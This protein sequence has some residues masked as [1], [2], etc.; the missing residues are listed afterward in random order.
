[1][2]VLVADKI[3][4][5]GIDFLRAQEDVDVVEAFGSSPEKL[6]ELA[7]D[8]DA[9]IVRSAS[10]VTAEIIA[11]APKLRAVG[12][13]GVGVDNIDVEAATDRG[14]IVMNTPGG[15][16]IATAE[17]AFT[18]LLCSARPVPQANASMKSGKWDKKS[19]SGTELFQKNLG[20]LGLGRIGAE[21]AKRANAFGMTVYA[22]DPYLTAA[23]AEQ[24]SVKKVDLDEL[25]AKADFITIHMP[26]TET[27]ENM[28]NA[29]AFAKMKKGVRIINCARGG[30][31]NEADLAVAL[32]QG[33]V[34]ATGLD[35]F[36]EEP[37]ADESPLRGF[38][39][40]VLTP[41]L[42]ASTAEAQENVGFEVAELI[43][44]ALRG[45][46]IRNSVNAPSIDPAVLKVLRPYLTLA[47]KMGTLVQQLTPDQVTKM[48][49]VYSGK[50]ADLDVK[51]LNRAIQRGYLRKITNDVND[52][53]APRIM[54]R[55]GISGEIVKTDLERDY[56]ELIRIEACDEDDQCHVVEGTLLGR[57]QRPRLTF[58]NG[59]ELECP[60]DEKYLLFVENED[61]PGIVGMI[62]SVLAKHQVNISNMSLSRNSVGGIAFNVCGLDSKP[63]A[64][65]VS[66]IEHYP[67]VKR[68]VLIDLNG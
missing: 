30:L 33:I 23:R 17:L 53:N 61:V 15:N 47:Y 43:V 32:E 14:V 54:D 52:V 19:F 18:H 41:H 68:T 16:T 38:D 4:Q 6:K 8:V 1:M 65:A 35:V 49:L 26:K 64:E 59:C 44:E 40:A 37:L 34:A 9:I 20:V 11:A 36:V 29:A 10:D 39:R 48:R 28:I 57:S 5:T 27:T 66:E 58:V 21:V 12:R 60:L 24:L 25:L 31:I 50:L 55:L 63:S 3:A 13:A 51:P 22:Y 62:G 7:A 45:G 42:G 56:T 67:N 2:K 46:Q